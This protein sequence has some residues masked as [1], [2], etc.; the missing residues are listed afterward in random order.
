MHFIP[1][2]PGTTSMLASHSL[3]CTPSP[4]SHTAA[5]LTH[6]PPSPAPHHP[7][8][9]PGFGFIT[10]EDER[11]ADDAVAGLDGKNG[12]KVERAR[13]GRRDGGGGG[14]G[15]GGYGGGGYGGGGVSFGA[16]GGDCGLHVFLVRSACPPPTF[17]T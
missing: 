13:P 9:Q 6:L 15:G 5:L 14:R 11:D 16:A 10:F 17:S 7:I 1:A 12:W 2:Q 3:H 4:P 8:I